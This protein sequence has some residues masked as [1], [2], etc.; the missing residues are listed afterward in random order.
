VGTRRKGRECA[1]HLL[2][3]ADFSPLDPQQAHDLYWKI[4]P[5]KDEQ[6]QVYADFLFR[7]AQEHRAEIDKLIQ[8]FSE[9]WRIER[10][11]AVDRNILRI[12]VFEFLYETETPTTVVINEALEIARK[13]S[14]EESTQFIN[15]ILDAINKH[16]LPTLKR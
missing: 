8:Q 4:H 9:H 15:G 16:Y 10:M 12:A 14:T 7:G 11:A 13:F 2:F 5:S 3:Q 6:V 1:L